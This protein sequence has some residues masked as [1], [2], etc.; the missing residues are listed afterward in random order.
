MNWV[1]HRGRN[2]HRL[3]GILGVIPDYGFVSVHQNSYNLIIVIPLSAV[4]TLALPVISF[5]ADQTGQESG[6]QPLLI[7]LGL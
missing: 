4:Y 2:Q 5:P 6:L 7:N 1:Q 3:K